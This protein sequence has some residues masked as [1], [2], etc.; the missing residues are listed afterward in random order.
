MKIRNNQIYKIIVFPIFLFFVKIAIEAITEFTNILPV[1][2]KA[3][4]ISQLDRALYYIIWQFVYTIWFYILFVYLVNIVFQKKIVKTLNTR[5]FVVFL[6]T[7]LFTLLLYIYN[8]EFPYKQLY[9]PKRKVFNYKLVQQFLVFSTL[10]VITVN[11][12]N[13]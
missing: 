13:K 11:K 10:I 9:F 7:F 4:I 2:P 8:F 3:F 6:I 12:F 5:Y 1:Q